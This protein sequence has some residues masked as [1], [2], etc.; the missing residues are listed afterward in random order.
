VGDSPTP[1]G[2]RGTIVELL[3]F[4][5]SGG[6][7]TFRIRSAHLAEGEHPDRLAG[8]DSAPPAGALVH[9]TSWRF[10]NGGVVL[11]YAAL[12]DL[13]PASAG[14]L[15][16]G[17]GIV[18]STDLLAPSP[19]VITPANVAA[20]ACRHLAVLRRTDPAVAAAA[21][22]VPGLWP[23]LDEYA[24]RTAVTSRIPATSATVLS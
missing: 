21:R 9:S 18:A 11:T 24:Y 12:P 22:E 6:E 3:L 2:G 23:L 13:L 10:D 16:R 8:F 1:A 4:G 15:D 19:A 14:R 20:H 5:T 17:A 7:L